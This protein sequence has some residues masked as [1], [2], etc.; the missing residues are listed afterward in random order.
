MLLENNYCC[1]YTPR[2]N[3]RQK[4]GR[5]DFKIGPIQNVTPQATAIN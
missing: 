4:D 2:G 3:A 5:G 1:D